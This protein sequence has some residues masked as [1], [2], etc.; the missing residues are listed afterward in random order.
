MF[1]SFVDKGLQKVEQKNQNYV[2][3]FVQKLIKNKLEVFMKKNSKISPLAYRFQ[4]NG[5]FSKVKKPAMRLRQSCF[6]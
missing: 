1:N 5:C 3:I 4:L 2:I 6:R